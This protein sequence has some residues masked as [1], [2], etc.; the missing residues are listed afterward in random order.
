MSDLTEFRDHCRRMTSKTTGPSAML[1]VL[2][3]DEVDAYLAGD[4]NDDEPLFGGDS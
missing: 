2:L 4:E 3:A 1:W